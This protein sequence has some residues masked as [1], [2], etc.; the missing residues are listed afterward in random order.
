MTATSYTTLASR[1]RQIPRSVRRLGV[2]TGLVLLVVIIAAMGSGVSYAFW[3]GAVQASTSTVSTGSID[4][5]VNGQ[6]SFAV[7]GLDTTALLPGRSVVASQPLTLS[8]TGSVPL[9]ITWSGTS[10]TSASTALRTSLVP[11]IR[12]AAAAT[13]S[14]TPQATP[15]A[16][17]LPA[18][19][20][21]PGATARICLEVRMSASAP[22]EVQG[23]QAAVGITLTGTQVRP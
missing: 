18:M 22:A 1:I 13:C 11:S 3:N 19:T 21:Q 10:V 23:H 15:L 12:P 16:T 8:N 17:A 7:T 14:I 6:A 2:A 5:R 4:L 9:A 20:I